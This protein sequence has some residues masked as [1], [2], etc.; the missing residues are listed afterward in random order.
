MNSMRM[1]FLTLSLLA[2]SAAALIAQTAG[3][4]RTA[5]SGNWN[6]ATTWQKYQGGAWAAAT[7]VPDSGVG[8]IEILAAHTVT[9]TS[10]IVVDSVYIDSLA[11]L[12]VPAGDT[13]TVGPPNLAVGS[14][15][16][17][18]VLGGGSMLI[19]GTYKHARD[20]GS[21]PKATWLPG[22]TCLVSPG[23]IV[24]ATVPTNRSQSF[25]N[26]EWN[27]PAQTANLALNL[28]GLSDSIKG[29]FVVRSTG[30]GRLYLTSPGT[31]SQVYAG[32][33][34]ILGDVILYKGQFAM[35]GTSS[36]L[37]GGLTFY[38]ANVGG[39]LKVNGDTPATS[40]FGLTRGSAAPAFWRVAG[41]VTFS[42][43]TLTT[44]NNMDSKVVF[45]K[46]GTQK[47]AMNGVTITSSAAF[48]FQV[49]NGAT[50][51][52][53]TNKVTGAGTFVLDNG[54][55]VKVTYGANSGGIACTGASNTVAYNN[56][57]VATAA[58]GSGT[59]TF[60]A[61]TP[62]S[63]KLSDTSKSLPRYY[64]VVADAGITAGT[65][66]VNYPVTEVPAT[67]TE[68]NLVPA[69]YSGTGTLWYAMGAATNATTHIA[70]SNA[71]IK[72]NGVWA[73]VD[74]S[75]LSG[76]SAQSS[77]VV[78]GAFEVGQNYPN[79]FNPSTQITFGLPKESM[80]TAKVFNLLGQEV[81]SLLNGRVSAGVHTLTFNAAKLG[82]GVY[83]CRI[84]AGSAVETRR[85]VLA[86]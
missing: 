50:V 19:S 3:D 76:V 44:S 54:G 41:D 64:T 74:P 66:V 34:N 72:I 5:Q 48:S 14:Q 46:A 52:I 1:C 59:A 65:M 81:A 42:N 79:P 30:T 83:F 4:Y 45:V 63:S 37:Q 40:N 51:D 47:L 10:N 18:A 58:T 21:F 61:A 57:A 26:F 78:P 84:Q 12:I 7:A 60:T 11:T 23:A 24:L 32:P 31:S 22:S 35:H 27:C 9:V 86:K 73:V 85:M 49:A 62:A 55:S 15:V 67:V 71:N 6:A 43:C 29:N 13:L 69:K 16:G 70:T 53:D 80:V 17:V 68:A 2:I 25:R 56:F 82:S 8:K 33:I 28:T 20:A 38:Q 39:N 77:S 75:I 36:A